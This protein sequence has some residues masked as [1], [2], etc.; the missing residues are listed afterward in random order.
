MGT[1][2]HIARTIR[3]YSRIGSVIPHLARPLAL[4][5]TALS[6]GLFLFIDAPLSA[7]LVAALSDAL[8]AGFSRLDDAPGF[9][10]EIETTSA[11]TQKYASGEDPP[12]AYTQKTRHA[13]E[14]RNGHKLPT[15]GGSLK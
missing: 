6:T 9:L 10:L 12:D 3:S 5:Y 7:L 15:S 2:L 4:P 8:A 1:N 13:R 11:V 14:R